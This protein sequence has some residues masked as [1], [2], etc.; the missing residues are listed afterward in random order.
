MK[1]KS[2]VTQSFTTL[3]DPV[4]CSLPG[5]SICGILQAG[6]LQWV[7]ISFSNIYTY[8]YIYV[9]VYIYTHTYTHT[10]FLLVFSLPPPFLLPCLPLSLLFMGWKQLYGPSELCS[11]LSEPYWHVRKR[12]KIN[13][14]VIVKQCIHF[15][16][17]GPSGS[18]FCW[19]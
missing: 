9:Y 6:I 14:T 19:S 3:R 11:C 13:L 8:I 1:V 4:D 10:F 17:L 2:E 5:S 15:P 7:A 18:R 16:P 12:G